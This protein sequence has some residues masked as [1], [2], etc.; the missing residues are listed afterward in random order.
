MNAPALRLV[1]VHPALRL[2]D[3]LTGDMPA[4]LAEGALCGFDPELH[5]GPDAFTG[6]S[7]D[8]QAAR[9]QVAREVC[10]ECP[11][12]VACLRRALRIRPETGVWA[13]FT[14]AELS[15][16]AERLDIFGSTQ[17]RAGVA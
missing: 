11:A 12:R 16:L 10:G 1:T 8:E 3:L 13:G 9:E 7:A 17:D 2:F 15:D 4:E 14:A 6:E 5:T